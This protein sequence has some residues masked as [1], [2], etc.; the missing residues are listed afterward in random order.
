MQT[1]TTEK[2]TAGSP[3]QEDIETRR[4]HVKNTLCC[5]YC[6]N[7]L[8]KWVV[9]DSPFNEWPNEFFYVCMNDE[10][11]YYV[12][13]WSTIAAIGDIGAYRLVYDPLKDR[14]FPAPL[15]RSTI[16]RG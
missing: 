11:S 16:P 9:P 6:E 2:L 13:S 3:S 12:Q 8:E 14:C 10:C 15:L 4:S 1:A 7:N 5:P